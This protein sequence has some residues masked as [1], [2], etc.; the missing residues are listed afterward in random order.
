VPAWEGEQVTT[1]RVSES[2]MLRVSAELLLDGLLV[3]VFSDDDVG[4]V[5]DD[6][7]RV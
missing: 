2:K 7:H 5:R 1:S 3:D 4:D 6:S